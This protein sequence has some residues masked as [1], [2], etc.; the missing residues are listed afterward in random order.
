METI[1]NEVKEAISD[2]ENKKFSEFSKKV[3]TSLEDKLRNNPVV[4]SKG[5][6]LKNLQ[7][8]KDTFAQIKKVEPEIE[9][10][11]TPTEPAVETPAED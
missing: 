6:E 10:E 9:P 5:D 4:K 8:M 3:K 7:K 1:I 2:A 11:E